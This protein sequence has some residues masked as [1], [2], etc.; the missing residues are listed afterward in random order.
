[1]KKDGF[2]LA[3]VLITLGIIGV[4]AAITIPTLV[5]N[6]QKKVLVTQLQKSVAL[7]SN[8]AKLLLAN[9]QTDNLNNTYLFNEVLSKEAFENS[10][11]KFL[12]TYF[13]VI[14]TCNTWDNNEQECIAETYKSLDGQINTMF[15]DPSTFEYC[16]IINNGTVIC[17][18]PFR[19][20]NP[21]R[22]ILDLNG[23]SGP[24]VVGRD[25]FNLDLNYNG[26]IAESFSNENSAYETHKPENCGLQ[27]EYYPYGV[28]C[29][30]RI[31]QNGWKMDY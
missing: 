24:N 22:I 9:E 6:Y 16:A 20:W 4:V 11:G 13:N 31:I 29:Y 19:N 18:A 30:N 12:K 14:K 26:S 1:M 5:A 23:K 27:G 7:I 21:A 15:S 28:G 3:E 8:G 17:L 25:L 10:V 2:T